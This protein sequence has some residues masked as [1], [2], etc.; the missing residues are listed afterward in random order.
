MIN[1]KEIDS[2]ADG[3]TNT[4]HRMEFR[5]EV[6][7]DAIDAFRWKSIIMKY[8]LYFQIKTLVSVQ[9]VHAIIITIWHIVLYE[10]YFLDIAIVSVNEYLCF[11]WRSVLILVQLKNFIPTPIE[12]K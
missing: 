7:A 9:C 12:P 6:L 3:P 1:R 5:M 11:D 4:K 2:D 10:I 8:I